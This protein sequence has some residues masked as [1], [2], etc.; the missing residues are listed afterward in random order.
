MRY[1]LQDSAE[2]PRIVE[3]NVNDLWAEEPQQDDEPDQEPASNITAVS[4]TLDALSLAQHA[5]ANIQ[6]KAF[7][8]LFVPHNRL[9]TILRGLD[10]VPKD[11]LYHSKQDLS[12]LSTKRHKI[13]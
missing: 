5:C 10:L 6:H 2:A 8:G 13:K 7:V 9:W 1:E 11:P 4:S 12:K 3:S